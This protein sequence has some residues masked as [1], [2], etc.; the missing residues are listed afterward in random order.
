MVNRTLMW[1]FW[2]FKLSFDVDILVFLANFSKNQA[3]FNSIFWSHCV[4]K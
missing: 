2:A 1:M 3:K 4:V